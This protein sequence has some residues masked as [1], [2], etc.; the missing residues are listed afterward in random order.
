MN[1]CGAI[2]CGPKWSLCLCILCKIGLSAFSPMCTLI[3]RNLAIAK[4]H[5]D[6]CSIIVLGVAF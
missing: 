6:K 1:K 2:K 3:T 5:T 4:D